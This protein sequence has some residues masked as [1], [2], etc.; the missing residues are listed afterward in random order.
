[1]INL[2]HVQNNLAI[3]KFYAMNFSSKSR[4]SKIY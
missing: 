4:F 3:L 1:M 2:F